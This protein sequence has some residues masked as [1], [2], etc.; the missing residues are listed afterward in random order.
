MVSQAT[1]E[2]VPIKEVRD[3]V[4]VLEDGSMRSILM[5]SS[6]NLALKSQD[7]QEAVLFQFQNLLNSLD[8]PVQFSIQSRKLDIKP[9]LNSLEERKKDQ[10]DDLLQIQIRE[11]IE[12]IKTFSENI[13]IM[14]KNFYVVI[15]YNPPSINVEKIKIPGFGKKTEKKTKI[16]TFEENRMQLDQRVAIVE[17]GLMRSGVR[18]VQLGTEE[19]VEIF[20]KI[21]NP[22]DI[23]KSFDMDLSKLQ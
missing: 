6:I 7:E 1:Q 15:P 18:S 23:E 9:Y 13:D 20:Y 3:G 17:Q 2:F 14:T 11:Y 12:F 8:F 21:F 22:G 10:T 19:V 16:E 5:A 4:L